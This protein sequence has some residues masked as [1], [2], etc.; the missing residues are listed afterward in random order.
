[1]ENE[2]FEKSKVSKAYFTL[3]LPVVLSMVIS[4]IYNMADTYFVAKTQNT[5]LVAAVSLCAPLFTLM[6]ALGDIFGI[7]G[8]SI[9]SRL[10][11]QKKDQEANSVNGF[12]CLGAIVCGV[13]VTILM[14]LFKNPL[15]N[16]L[17][18][19]TET[20]S[21]A[22]SYYTIIAIGATFII[23]QLSPSN[24]IRTEGLAKESMLGTILGS[25]INIILDPIFI[26]VLN[27]GAK[28][29]AIATIIGYIASDILFIYFMNH[30]SN[31][32]DFKFKK[33]QISKQEFQQILSIGIPA[34][35]TNLMASL[36]TTITNR[37]LVTFGNDKVA[38]M[39]IALKVNMIIMLIMVGFAFGAQPLIGYNY[40]AKNKERLH[41]I[42]RFDILVEVIF[43]I[44]T[45]II[46]GIF[47]PNI[48]HCFMQDTQ[49]IETGST[50][51]RCLIISSPCLGLI[52]VFTTLFQSEGK[53]LPALI[54]SISRQGIIYILIIFIFSQTL[55]Y[56]GII[57]SQAISDILTA[58]LAILI[59]MKSKKDLKSYMT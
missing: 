15:L 33:Y 57:I 5:N 22:S 1:M 44:C 38:A 7:G 14:L 46:L 43:A 4:L 55:G 36:A 20:M 9:I 50:M 19:N 23:F 25:I 21:Y 49:I 32:L 10:F 59:Y 56:T 12:C 37:Y 26:L 34:S 42:I 28:G 35:T 18:A 41:Q 2:L 27:L 29:A 8:S 3:A 40:G 24:I 47:A 39:G 58:L 54:L 53:A 13:T 17:G 6:V 52:L 11:G 30:R 48:I 16:L 45:S 31:K 51:L